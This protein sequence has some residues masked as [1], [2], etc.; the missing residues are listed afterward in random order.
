MRRGQEKWKRG[1]IKMKKIF[2]FLTLLIFMMVFLNYFYKKEY[3]QPQ[4]CF[5]KNCFLVD[6]ALTEKERMTGLMFKE[7]L[8]REK[9]MLF[10]FEN[11][12]DHSFWMKNVLIPLD[13][14]WLDQNKKV[15]Y[16][17]ENCQ[18]CLDPHCPSIKPNGRAKYVLEIK[19]GI[20]QEIGL[21]VGERLEFKNIN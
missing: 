13:I 21:S 9:G 15:I 6:L 11:E 2:L 4:V 14:I 1:I 17:A 10:I 20:S 8:E 5:K 12:N 7:N 18:P 19:G 16:L 3:S